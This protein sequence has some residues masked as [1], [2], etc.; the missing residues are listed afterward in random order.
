MHPSIRDEDGFTLIEL[1]VVILIIGILAAI[2]LPAFLG[3]RVKGQD[4]AAKSDARNMVS[5]V[6]SCFATKASYAAC[7]VAATA[8]EAGLDLIDTA[9]LTGAAPP[10]DGYSITAKSV[11]GDTFTIAKDATGKVTRT[12]TE[13]GANTGKGGCNGS[14]W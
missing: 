6:E 1:L 7:N 2:A 14:S 13:T 9:T 5:E 3:P 4:S 10:A 11:S 12:C 8:S